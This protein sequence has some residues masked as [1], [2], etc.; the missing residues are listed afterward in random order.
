MEIERIKIEEQRKNLQN[1]TSFE[2]EEYL[3]LRDH[4]NIKML[5]ELDEQI[6]RQQK[7]HELQLQST[8]QQSA[9]NLRVLV[10]EIR[11]QGQRHQLEEVQQKHQLQLET[12]KWEDT[13][14]KQIFEKI[15][16]GTMPSL[17]A[18]IRE[19]ILD[20]KSTLNEA[21]REPELRYLLDILSGGNPG[22]SIP[23]LTMPQNPPPEQTVNRVS[24]VNENQSNAAAQTSVTGQFHVEKTLP[25]VVHQAEETIEIPDFGMKL[26]QTT[27]SDELHIKA[28]TAVPI[29]FIVYMLNEHGPASQSQLQVADIIIAINDHDIQNVQDISQAVSTRENGTE[30]LLYILRGQELKEVKLK[31]LR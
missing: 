15:G 3:K 12:Q 7:T 22:V 25:G 4:E 26:I 14:R 5:A 27:F 8:E 1:Q 6:K 28:G 23:L 31:T 16:E 24:Q 29:G 17:I 13:M 20:E 30:V 10:E 9:I 21:A 11:Q 2:R 18:R 19:Q